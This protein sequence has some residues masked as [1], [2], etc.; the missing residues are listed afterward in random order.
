MHLRLENSYQMA[1]KESKNE[2]LIYMIS[3]YLSTVTCP[4]L[5]KDQTKT[6]HK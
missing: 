2:K 4:T 3:D 1:L 6:T 5:L